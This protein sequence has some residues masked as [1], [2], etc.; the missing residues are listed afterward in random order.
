MKTP[1]VLALLEALRAERLP[2]DE[3]EALSWQRF[4]SAL[5]TLDD[6]CNELANT[7][8]VTSSAIVIGPRG[9]LLHRH[10]RLG[11]WLQPGGHIDP[12]EH[13]ADAAVRETVEET[14]IAARHRVPSDLRVCHVDVHDGPR[15]HLHLDL[16]YL[17]EADDQDPAPP[18]GE[19]QDVR[20]FSWDE[21]ATI[22]EPGLAGIIAAI[23]PTADKGVS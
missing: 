23:R 11:I 18:E 2:V 13:P 22:T 16:R 1:D 17:L 20:W 12:G 3:R 14:G 5:E 6:P 19:S 15:G 4:R 10:K 7:T 8:H 21:A 9:L